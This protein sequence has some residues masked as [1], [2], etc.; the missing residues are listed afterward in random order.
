MKDAVKEREELLKRELDRIVDTLKREYQPQEIILFGSVA[1]G[2]IHAWSDIDLL[3][4][5]ETEKRPIDR[6]LEVY[7]IVKP[8]VGID[9]FVYTRSEFQTLLSENVSF[10]R[11]VI[12]GG[13]SLYAQRE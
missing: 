3:I 8:L 9:V 12:K 13:T 4:V 5:K 11:N 2:E 7:R 6:C 10:I 1:N